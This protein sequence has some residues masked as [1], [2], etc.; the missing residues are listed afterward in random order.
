MPASSKRLTSL[1]CLISQEINWRLQ[2]TNKKL[3]NKYHKWH[4]EE[5]KHTIRKIDLILT[6]VLELVICLKLVSFELLPTNWS[7][8]SVESFLHG[9]TIALLLVI[10]DFYVTRKE[11]LHILQ[12]IFPSLIPCVWYE[13]SILQYKTAFMTPLYGLYLILYI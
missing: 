9:S 8:K 13:L 7:N 12:G 6:F 1:N 3:E 4:W 10:V 5:T 11:K 2:F